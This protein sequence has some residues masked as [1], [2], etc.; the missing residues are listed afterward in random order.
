MCYLFPAVWVNVGSIQEALGR[1]ASI[2]YPFP[3]PSVFT[4]D[5]R[6]ARK[7]DSETNQPMPRD[8]LTYT[9]ELRVKS[10]LPRLGE[11]H[12]RRMT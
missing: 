9:I 5:V 3:K 4:D 1:A 6:R 7:R 8:G 2:N 11:L 10:P 12:K